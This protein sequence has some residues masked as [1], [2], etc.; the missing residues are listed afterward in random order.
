MSGCVVV[1]DE[2][3]KKKWNDVKEIEVVERTDVVG[4]VYYENPTIFCQ[5]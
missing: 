1:Y 3:P 5:E 2:P 4:N